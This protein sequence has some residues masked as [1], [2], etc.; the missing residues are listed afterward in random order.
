MPLSLVWAKRC[1]LAGPQYI[2]G[3]SGSKLLFTG[4]LIDMLC[5]DGGALADDVASGA[6]IYERESAHLPAA[7][8]G[9]KQALASLHFVPEETLR[10]NDSIHEVT[11]QCVQESKMTIKDD[12]AFIIRDHT[13]RVAQ[14][15]RHG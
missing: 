7:C 9:F 3:P 14:S 10:C 6:P 4:L 1:M 2:W 11:T 12:F 8:M 15:Q 5:M 13:E